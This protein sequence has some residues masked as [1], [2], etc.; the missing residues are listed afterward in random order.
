MGKP[1]SNPPG[2]RM[3]NTSPITPKTAA[4]FGSFHPP[5][6]MKGRFRSSAPIPRGL[7]MELLSPFSRTL[8]K[9]YRLSR[10]QHNRRQPSGSFRQLVTR[11][12][13]NLRSWAIPPVA[14][15][16]RHGRLM[17]NTLPFALQT[18]VRLQSG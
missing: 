18:L 3:V 10:L 1:T 4:V 15:E 8:T 11:N 13:N 17:D 7:R 6:G 12:P 2:L 14:T 9:L 5:E 16:L